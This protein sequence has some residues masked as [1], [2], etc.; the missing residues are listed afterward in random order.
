VSGSGRTL[1]SELK[2]GYG[3]QA[4]V[5][6]SAPPGRFQLAHRPAAAAAAS[7]GQRP[8]LSNPTADPKSGQSWSEGANEIPMI[9]PSSD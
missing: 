8:C 9:E 6:G 5:I 1:A 3:V 2:A 7:S 4:P